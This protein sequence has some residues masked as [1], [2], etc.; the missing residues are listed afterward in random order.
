VSGE[1]A[2][3]AA[4]R[5]PPPPGGEPARYAS[6]RPPCAPSRRRIIGEFSRLCC[7]TLSL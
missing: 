2:W 4:A 1:L 6:Y 5:P 7:E 3:A